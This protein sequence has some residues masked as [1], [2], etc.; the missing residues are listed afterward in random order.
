[1][2][3]PH[4]DLLAWDT[5]KSTAAAHAAPNSKSNKSQRAP[6]C[7]WAPQVLMKRLADVGRWDSWLLWQRDTEQQRCKGSPRQAARD[8]QVEVQ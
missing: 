7:G 6:R 2:G 5:W 1:M 4:Y 3:S 8:M